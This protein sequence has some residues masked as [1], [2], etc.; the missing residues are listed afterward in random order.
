[1]TVARSVAFR[2]VSAALIVLGGVCVVLR[3]PRPA[4]ASSAGP[5]TCS[6]AAGPPV[7]FDAGL[8]GDRA[9]WR[10]VVSALGHT[11]RVCLWDRPGRGNGGPLPAGRALGVA[12]VARALHRAL[13]AAQARGPVILVGHSTGGLDARLFALRYP[14]EVAA[15]VLS[16]PTSTRELLHGPDRIT[17]NGETL[18][19]HAAARTLAH[20]PS[21]GDIPLAV[22][23][24]GQDY[25]RAWARAQAALSTQS[26]N[27]LLVVAERSDHGVPFEQ[28]DLI[29]AVILEARH[30]IRNHSHLSCSAAIAAAHGACLPSG[31]VLAA[32]P[33][34][35]WRT[36][37]IAIAIVTITGLIG[38][39]VVR[40]ARRRP[41]G[42]HDRSPHAA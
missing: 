23:E 33:Q 34:P 31:S 20:A 11:V 16:E 15:L 7:V 21:R 27:S 41:S 40:R 1:M 19:V 26:L 8:G 12:Q 18:G 5:V 25:D 14:R 13:A 28:P 4:H 2:W 10:A 6:A 35:A 9:E 37:G 32:P 42:P 29:A 39:L 22:I 30:A 17:N 24:R 38:I 3:A 36:I